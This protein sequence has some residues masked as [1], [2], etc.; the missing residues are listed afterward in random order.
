MA[1]IFVAATATWNGKA[2]GKGK[3][4]LNAFEQSANKLR[5]NMRKE[6]AKSSKD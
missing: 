5:E 1:N 3:K 2:L 6:N 4:D